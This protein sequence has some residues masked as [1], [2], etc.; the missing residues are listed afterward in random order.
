[1]ANVTRLASLHLG[2][3][4]TEVAEF[5][6]SFQGGSDHANYAVALLGTA[7][8]IAIDL[9]QVP[10]GQALRG[11][12]FCIAESLG[13]LESLGIG[14]SVVMEHWHKNVI[15]PLLGGTEPRVDGGSGY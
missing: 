14:M 13:I 9:S 8:N 7:Y 11:M 2:S 12:R 4:K 1:M 15:G 3:N 5:L 10:S 6:H